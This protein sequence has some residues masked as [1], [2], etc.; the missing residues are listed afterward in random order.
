[1]ICDRVKTS[2]KPQTIYIYTLLVFLILSNKRQ[3]KTAEP[4]GSKFC[5]GSHMTGRFINDK[6]FKNLPPTKFDFH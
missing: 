2:G 3:N 6:N 5:V 4:F 1:M